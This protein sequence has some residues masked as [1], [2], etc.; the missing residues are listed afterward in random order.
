MVSQLETWTIR[1]TN[2]GVPVAFVAILVIQ[3]SLFLGLLILMSTCFYIQFC[4][5]YYREHRYELFKP[6][7]A[8]IRRPFFCETERVVNA[9]NNLPADV[10]FSTTSI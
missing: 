5:T 3:I 9:W 2:F 10:N 4:S 8:G 1:S 6:N 7:S